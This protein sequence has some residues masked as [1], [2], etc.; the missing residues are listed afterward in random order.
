MKISLFSPALRQLIV[1][2]AC[3]SLLCIFLLPLFGASQLAAEQENELAKGP[4]SLTD[5]ANFNSSQTD[6]SRPDR[7]LDV[8][9]L[10]ASVQATVDSDLSGRPADVKAAAGAEEAPSPAVV[11]DPVD[12]WLSNHICIYIYILSRNNPKKTNSQITN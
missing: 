12:C 3:I 6:K 10:N 11:L 4:V 2:R 1:A 7:T 5:L 9:D 8:G